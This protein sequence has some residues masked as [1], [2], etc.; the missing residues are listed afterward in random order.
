ML[1]VSQHAAALAAR[2]TGGFAGVSWT[3][4]LD[5][6]PGEWLIAAGKKPEW[7][8]ATALATHRWHAHEPLVR[9]AI[10]GAPGLTLVAS[11]AGCEESLEE[12]AALL[13]AGWLTTTAPRLRHMLESIDNGVVIIDREWRISYV[14]RCGA[15]LINALPSDLLGR[16]LL[17][18]MPESRGSQIEHVCQQVF[19]TGDSICYEAPYPALN[20]WFQVKVFLT[21]DEL[22][23]MFCETTVHRE[24]TEH[25]E[26]VE[27]QLRQALTRLRRIAD[28]SRDMIC[29]WTAEGRYQT[30]S[31]AVERI[32]GY[33]P[34]EMRGKGLFDLVA[35][36]DLEATRQ[37]AS[38]IQAGQAVSSFRNRL[39]HKD[40]HLVHLD[41][42]S[43]WSPEE[44]IGFAVARDITA[45]VEAESWLME[46]E[47][48]Y[49]L[50]FD[51]NPQQMWMYDDENYEILAVNEAALARYGYTREEFLNLTV[52]DLVHPDEKEL[53]YSRLI[54]QRQPGPRSG[55]WKHQDKDGTEMIVMGWSH[56]LP[57]AGRPARL[58]VAIDVTQE[59]KLEEQLRQAQKMEAIGELAGGIA[60][61]FNNLLTVINGYAEI[62]LR[63]AAGTPF[64]PMLAAIEQ[65]GNRAALLTTQLLAFS[66]RQVLQP[67]LVSLNQIVRRVEPMLRR[68]TPESLDID[69]ALS[70]ELAVVRADA[71][72]FEHVL[73]NLVINAR[74]AME[75][76]QGRI[77][78]ETFNVMLD[79]DFA[80]THADVLPG[81]H[82]LMTVTDSGH[83]MDS[84]TAA[85]VFE[86]FFTTKPRGRGT[87]LG[88][89]MAYG[90]VKQS[91]GHMSV[92]SEPGIGTSMK[93][94][95]PAAEA[96][97]GEAPPLDDSTPSVPAAAGTETILLVEDDERVR[98]FTRTVLEDLG[99]RVIEAEDG[100][101]ALEQADR[102]GQIDLLLSDVVLPRLSGREIA[103]RLAPRRPQ[104]RVLFISGYTENAIVHHG[105]LDAGLNFLPKPFTPDSLAR[106]VREVLDTPLRP[107]CIL[108]AAPSGPSRDELNGT[109]HGAGY[110]T[111]LATTSAECL[112]HTS[113]RAVDLILTPLELPGYTQAEALAFFREEF[114]HIRVAVLSEPQPSLR[115]DAFIPAKSPAASLVE[116]VRALTG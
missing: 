9:L 10:P 8:P 87:G 83:G 80:A 34:E 41:W 108:L 85:R 112:K 57:L 61:D 16:P 102:A 106:K 58:S 89:P 69:I 90:I 11:S 51:L 70:P 95:L 43:A 113:R 26:Q 54:T 15:S 59:R 116:A 40:G 111:I 62:G 92:Y 22:A 110:T 50:I 32:L 104:M 105:V 53:A 75:G 91:G 55:L 103:Q 68:I 63:A 6:A 20:A 114:P 94:Y 56:P 14:N 96:F 64:E 65:A 78:I 97:P 52:F 71:A 79:E 48:R 35:P 67:E 77:V 30:V 12:V 23:I 37:I 1:V 72:Q 39:R 115:P 99:Y 66:R 28:S 100:N 36:E 74:D 29:T 4:N 46:S 45:Y 88:L 42:S 21:G 107:R 19:E 44:N 33:T 5:G 47:A 2:L 60:H 101:A 13:A 73:L 81:P 3:T 76:R 18:V 98:R 84:A 109:L 27:A 86:P 82:V 31:R 38:A 49:R 7:L 93:V 24:R 25:L 17:D